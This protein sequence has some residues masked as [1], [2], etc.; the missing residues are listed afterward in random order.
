MTHHH[1]LQVASSRSTHSLWGLVAAEFPNQ[2]G[3]IFLSSV[4]K[5]HIVKPAVWVTLQEELVEL[6][7]DNLDDR[8]VAE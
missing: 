3:I 2:M 8:N 1:H 7:L 6:H 4:K 5:R